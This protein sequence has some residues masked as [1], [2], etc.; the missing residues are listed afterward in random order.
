MT[1]TAYLREARRL[2]QTP[3]FDAAVLGMAAD[4]RAYYRDNAIAARIFADVGQLAIVSCLIAA[5][6]P[7]TEAA[8][9]RI[10]GAGALASR[11]RVRRHI[12]KLEHLG[13]IATLPANDARVRPLTPTPA[14]EHQLNQWVRAL[15]GQ[16]R[17]LFALDSAL[18]DDPHL[19]R[20]YLA[21][22]MQSHQLGFS[23]F[24][25]TPSIARIVT[26]SRG[27]ALVL[28][29]LAAHIET[30]TRDIAFSRRAF[31]AAYGVSR[32]HVIDLIKECA[33]I[34]LLAPDANLQLTP[35]FVTQARLWAAI[36]FVLA[37]ATLERRLIPALA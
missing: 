34:G 31:G 17:H 18:L 19:A 13:L 2:E 15:A 7:V 35:A 28:E 20:T 8:L 32:T 4:L 14:L 29:W 33:D 30:N 27:H 37:A 6:E 26:L 21:Q 1:E 3:A 23:A 11:Q 25:A 16:A 24:E 36:N 12:G 10:V 5:P 22:V 9:C